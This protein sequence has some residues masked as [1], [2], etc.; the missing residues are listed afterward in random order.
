YRE[1][2]RNS[3]FS[4]AIREYFN[5]SFLQQSDRFHEGYPDI[6]TTPEIEEESYKDN[7]LLLAKTLVKLEK[8]A[9][10]D[11]VNAGAYYYMLGNAWY[12]LSELGWFVNT[13]HYLGGGNDSR[14]T[15]NEEDDW[16]N[17]DATSYSGMLETAVF[18]F[19]KAMESTSDE[20]IKAKAAFFKA[21]S[22]MCYRAEWS[23]E[24][25]SYF[26]TDFCGEHAI[27]FEQ[28]TD[29]ENTKFYQEVIKECTYFKAYL[30]Q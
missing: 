2:I 30:Q 19:N 12:N 18:Y 1:G 5:V 23:R 29:Y 13:L 20:E 7:K 9:E 11:A 14:Y 10:E 21:K 15:I 26:V 6:F 28:L 16:R 25:S 17:Q 8:L 24:A 4:A 22:E 27:G 3:L